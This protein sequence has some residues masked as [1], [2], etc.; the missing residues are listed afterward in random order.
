MQANDRDISQS[1]AI[2]GFPDVMGFTTFVAFI[3]FTAFT[4]SMASGS[5]A[6]YSYDSVIVPKEIWPKYLHTELP[7][8]SGL[9]E[10]PRS[11][12]RL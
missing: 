12:I 9:N 11:G 2:V 5:A 7:A 3:A 6:L 8:P 4:I 1:K 10:Y